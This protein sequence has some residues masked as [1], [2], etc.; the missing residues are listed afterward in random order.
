[1]AA[2]PKTDEPNENPRSP[3][4]PPRFARLKRWVSDWRELTW[5]AVL[6]AGSI[7]GATLSRL[8]GENSGQTPLSWFTD[9]AQLS[10]ASAVV[11]LLAWLIKRALI[12]DLTEGEVGAAKHHIRSGSP[13]QDGYRFLL[14]LDAAGSVACFLLVVL[15][16]SALY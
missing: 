8:Y 15:L 14:K 9:L 4:T 12:G 6:F 10:A 13:H 5:I 1:M 11:S 2:Q 3:Q 16:W 7:A